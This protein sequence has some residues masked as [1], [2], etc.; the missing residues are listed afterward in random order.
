MKLLTQQQKD[1]LTKR[2]IEVGETILIQSFGF[3]A[4]PNPTLSNFAWIE[5]DPTC[6]YELKI[7]EKRNRFYKVSDGNKIEF[8]VLAETL[9]K[10]PLIEIIFLSLVAVT[11]MLIFNLMTKLK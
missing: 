3:Y 11:P 6:A 8:W 5:T 1:W 2:K 4:F 7:K 9:E 10:R